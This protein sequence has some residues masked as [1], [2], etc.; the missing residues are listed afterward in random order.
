VATCASIETGTMTSIDRPISRPSKPMPNA[1]DSS[2]TA[3][4]AGL[5]SSERQA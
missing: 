3:A 1:S 2:V 4:K 5:F